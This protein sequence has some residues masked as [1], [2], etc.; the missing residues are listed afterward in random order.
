MDKKEIREQYKRLPPDMGIYEVKNLASGKV[1]IGRALDLK[2]KLNSERF[3]LKNNLHRNQELQKDFNE[4]GAERFS[5]AVLDRLPARESPDHDPGQELKELE[6]IWLDK[7]QPYGERGY[8]K[9]K[10]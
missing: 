6:E 8:H 9:R 5:F 7:L 4:L 2:G 3:Q 1:L 10:A